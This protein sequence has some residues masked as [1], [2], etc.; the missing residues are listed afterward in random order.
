MTLEEKKLLLDIKISIISIDEHLEGRRAF[1]EYKANKTKRR[2]VERELEIIGEA[3]SRLLK[4]NE[5]IP[6]S[7]A[8]TIVDLRNRVIH[9]Y[10]NIDDNIIWKIVMKDIPTLLDEV[11]NLLEE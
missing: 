2:A 7:Y 4:L 5:I 8:R 10:D 3:I 9:A 6:L 11:N 1:E